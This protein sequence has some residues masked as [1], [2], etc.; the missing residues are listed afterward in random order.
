MDQAQG[1]GCLSGLSLSFRSRSGPG[2]LGSN[3]PLGSLLRG[4]LASPR[5]P[6]TLPTCDLSFSVK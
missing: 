3:P 5:P 2:V 1:P 4:E 6:V